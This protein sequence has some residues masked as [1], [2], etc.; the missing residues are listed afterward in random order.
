M[1]NALLDAPLISETR[2]NHGLEHA[3]IHILSA[4]YPGLPMGGHSN[5][6]GFFIIA[7]VPTDA[8]RAAVSEGLSRM[9][10]GERHL[11]VHPGCGTN[12][13]V[14]G[15]VAGLLAWLG[16]LGARNGRDRLGRLPNVMALATLGFMI[17]QPL[18][19]LIQERITTSG[20]PGGMTIVDV[21]P[22]SKG[23]VTIHRVLTRG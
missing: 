5:P 23:N 18:A 6:T 11:A 10:A 15:A 8:V 22:V 20:D 2:R 1:P 7:N 19:P 14:Y 21:Y 9:L 17:A 13:V 16:M 12:Y 3:T 4:R